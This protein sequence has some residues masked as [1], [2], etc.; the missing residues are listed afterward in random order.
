MK[1]A[2]LELLMHIRL[3]WWFILGL[4]VSGMTYAGQQPPIA[5]GEGRIQQVDIA[6]YQLRISG[7]DYGVLLDANVEIGGSFGAFTL[8][9]QGMLV[10]FEY[11]QFPEGER[12]IIDIREVE[13]I[14][15]L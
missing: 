15:G 10:E 1:N 9:K 12:V 11:H 6:A 3:S 4:W 13:A 14:Q 2:G 5:E 8:L 7:Y